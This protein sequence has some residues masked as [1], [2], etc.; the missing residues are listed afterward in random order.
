MSKIKKVKKGDTVK[1]LGGRDR[2]KVAKILAVWPRAGRVVV[3]GVNMVHR[4]IKPRRSGERGQRVAVAAPLPVAAVQLVCPACRRA[5]R[6]V[7]RRQ[8]A[9][10]LRLCRKCQAALDASAPV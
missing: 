5:T 2:G 9:R 10:C 3:E 4:H 7:L 1:V 8:Q 6:V